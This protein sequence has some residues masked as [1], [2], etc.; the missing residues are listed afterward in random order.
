MNS[1]PSSFSRLIDIFTKLPGVGHKTAERYAFHLLRFKKRDLEFF[2]GAILNFK[3]K[4]KI[5]KNCF[6][7]SDSDLCNICSDE[8]RDRK[9]LC[10]VENIDDMYA[11]EKSGAYNGLY[12]IL[13]GVLSPMDG[14]SPEDIRISELIKKISNDNL[15]LWRPLIKADKHFCRYNSEF[16]DKISSGL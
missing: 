10:I 2:A 5:C 12:H 6:A 7:L 16:Q 14:I 4:I 8:N 9:I 15:L 3:D 13:Q 11:I 1:Y